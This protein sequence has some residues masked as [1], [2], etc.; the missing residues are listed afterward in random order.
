M[1][2]C[3]Q[4]QARDFTVVIDAGHGGHDPGALGKRG[5]EKNI[6]LSV[7]LK[8]GELIRKNCSDVRVVYTRKTDVFIP[9]DRR[10]QIANNAKADLFI[11]VHTNSVA[12][13]STV[14]GAETY[15]L[16]LHRTT[17]NLE[18]AKKENSVIL[19][20]DNY[21]Q[22]YAGF[23]PN[24]AES[25]IMFEFLQD[26]YMAQSVQL[27]TLIQRQFKNTAHRIDKGVHQAGFLVLRAT[28]MPSV[29]VE[30][31]YISTPDEEEY[32][33]SDNGSS[34]LAKSIYN[35]FLNYKEKNRSTHAA[36]SAQTV[37]QDAEPDELPAEEEKPAPEV[38]KETTKPATTKKQTT[39]SGKPVFKIQI[40][41]SSTVLPK[42]S[43]KLKGLSPV[44]YYKEGGI[45]KYTYG[46][47][48]DYNKVLR[49]KREIT[50]K[51]KDCFIIAF[52]NGEKTD[53]S[54]AIRE[55]K[56]GK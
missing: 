1:A 50:A 8:L 27:A 36:H 35:A 18:V 29:L 34:A 12:K 2:V 19:I 23:N 17:E 4:V 46:E 32:L 5:K 47:S 24:S 25:Y 55:F 38:K 14:R 9:L 33:L 26:K 10:A 16:G 48:T 11:S 20:E 22:R 15:T 41:T 30:L 40:L 44:S 53:V 28:S 51:F 52:K 45:Y 42:G 37:H 6:N 39:T 54:A 31:G 13:G 7:A 21:E 3:T 56:S 43:S 49:T